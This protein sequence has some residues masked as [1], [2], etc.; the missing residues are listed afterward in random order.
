MVTIIWSHW[1]LIVAY[2]YPKC[3]PPEYVTN[4]FNYMGRQMLTK[5]YIR[6]YTADII[7]QQLGFFTLWNDKLPQWSLTDLSRGRHCPLNQGKCYRVDWALSLTLSPFP[8]SFSLSVHIHSLQD[9]VG[10]NDSNCWHLWHKSI[11]IFRLTIFLATLT[12]RREAACHPCY[13][14]I[15]SSFKLPAGPP[16]TQGPPWGRCLPP[17]S[18]TSCF[19]L[20][21][22]S[23]LGM[24]DY[25]LSIVFTIRN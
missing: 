14:N 25:L 17:Q 5:S 4:T 18:P 7:E 21:G 20:L 22:V 24:V 8:I 6:T 15:S 10:I 2:P 19:A 13:D 3:R 11:N 1:A 23:N 16:W 9:S 12:T